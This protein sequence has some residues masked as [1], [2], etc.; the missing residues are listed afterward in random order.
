MRNY[1]IPTIA[2]GLAV[3]I[4]TAMGA[5]AQGIPYAQVADMLRSAGFEQI[6]IDAD[7][8]AS[9]SLYR[10]RLGPFADVDTASSTVDD[11]VALGFE[12][13]HLVVG[14]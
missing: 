8:G 3:A 1:R 14:P 11:L 12:K 6:N 13:P 10:V 7:R 9:T 2:A 5:S 4:G